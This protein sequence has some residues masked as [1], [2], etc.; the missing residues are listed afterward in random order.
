M[1]QYYVCLKELRTTYQY[2]PIT[3]A[4]VLHKY[5]QITEQIFVGSCIQT[6]KDVKMLSETMVCSWHMLQACLISAFCLHLLHSIY[7]S[8]YVTIQLSF[9]YFK[10]LQGI[11]AVLNF[12][13]ESERINWGINSEAINSSCRENN[14]LMVNYPIRYAVMPL[15]RR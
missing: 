13:S 15:S 2:I 5:S 12:Q 9:W 1:C 7:T 6:E 4:L 14:I 3:M 8:I 10:R 11:T